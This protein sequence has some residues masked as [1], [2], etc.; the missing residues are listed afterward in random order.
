[1]RVSWKAARKG[2]RGLFPH[3]RLAMEHPLK[4]S[5]R[6]AQLL[7]QLGAPLVLPSAQSVRTL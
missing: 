1:M 7:I 6:S 3:T 4:L 5:K 2:K